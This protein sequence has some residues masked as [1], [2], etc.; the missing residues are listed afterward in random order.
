MGFIYKVTNNCNGKVY[1]GQSRTHIGVRFEQHLRDARRTDKQS[2]PFYCAINKYGEKN[3]SLSL[4]EEVDNSL[5][6]EREVYWIDYYRSYIGFDDCQGY[7]A[8]L[9]GDSKQYYDYKKI[10][11]DYL[12]TKSKTQTAK[13]CNC[14]IETVTRALLT[15]NIPLVNNSAG[16]SIKR[17]DDNGQ[18]IVYKTIRQAAQEIA[19]NTGKKMQT[20]RK[21]INYVALH[22]QEQKAYGYHWSFI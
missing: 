5:L 9:G 22:K 14:C 10:V 12:L 11:D 3:F 16:R 4:I 18:E 8:T 19:E 6:N 1:I 15:Y 20:V 21:R 7:N 2:R 17:I 13:N